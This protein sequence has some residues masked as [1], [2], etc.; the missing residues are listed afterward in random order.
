VVQL[1]FSTSR[2]L[3]IIISVLLVS[4]ALIAAEQPLSN[5]NPFPN[6]SN[7]TPDTLT[8]LKAYF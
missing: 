1:K 4:T 6:N 3:L 7:V 8:E 2:L 5:W